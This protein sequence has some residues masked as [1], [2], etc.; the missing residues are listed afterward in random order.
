MRQRCF[1]SCFAPFIR[2]QYCSSDTC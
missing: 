2:W 1:S